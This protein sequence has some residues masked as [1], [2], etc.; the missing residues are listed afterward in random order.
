MKVVGVVLFKSIRNNSN[1]CL[2]SPGYCHRREKDSEKKQNN[3]KCN[4]SV[5]AIFS[6]RYVCINRVWILERVLEEDCVAT[7]RESRNW[8][9]I[10]AA[11]HSYAL[12]VVTSFWPVV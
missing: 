6:K 4:P 5:H 9:L 10:F 12:P 1:K 7:Q 8:V 11:K 3:T 2:V